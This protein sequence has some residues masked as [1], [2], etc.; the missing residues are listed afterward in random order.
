[1]DTQET[2]IYTVVLITSLTLGI[3]IAYFIISIIRQQRRYLE[4]QKASILAEMAAM[5]KE[6]AR[7][8]AD[9]HDD[10]GPILSVIKFQVDNVEGIAGEEKEQLLQASEHLDSLIGRVREIANN[11]MPTALHR[12]GLIT[13]IEEFLSKAREASKLKIEFNHIEDLPL[14]EE[15]SINIY[16]AIQEVVHNCMKHA[17]A[18]V[19]KINIDVKNGMII[20]LC[21]DNGKGFDYEKMARQSQGIGLRSL[22]NRTEMMGGTLEVESKD[23][24]GTAF[25]FEI[26]IR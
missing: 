24:K 19:V 5:E 14:P 1:M 18:S 16:R 21:K 9:L 17:K 25:L 26:P 10:L 22:K 15:T 8:A 12:K 6:R 23:G 13:A 4:L 2:R 3:I 20:I 7:I 11:L